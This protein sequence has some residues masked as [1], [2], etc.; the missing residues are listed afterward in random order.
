M[1]HFFLFGNGGGQ[2]FDFYVLHTL[3]A[4][5]KVRVSS[6]SSNNKWATLAFCDES[7]TFTRLLPIGAN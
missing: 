2:A 1:S 7:V 4:G 3:Q 5:L 6:R